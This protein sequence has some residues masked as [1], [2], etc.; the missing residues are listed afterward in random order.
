MSKTRLVEWTHN[1]FHG[2]RTLAVRVPVD[3]KAG[4][5]IQVSPALARRLNR[6]VCRHEDCQCGERVVEGIEQEHL[7]L[8]PE[9]GATV[10]GAYPQD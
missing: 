2:Y 7:L 3:A 1:G 5:I 6:A 10:R 8:V 4:D 9:N